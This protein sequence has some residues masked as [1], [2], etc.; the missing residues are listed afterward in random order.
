VICGHQIVFQDCC[1]TSELYTCTLERGHLTSH[2]DGTNWWEGEMMAERQLFI[3]R[4]DNAAGAIFHLN[5]DDEVKVENKGDDVYVKV[6]PKTKRKPAARKPA[7]KKST[8]K[9]S[10]AKKR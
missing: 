5:S 4:D 9:K 7:A 2:S 8:A 10:T 6:A 1:D 3:Q